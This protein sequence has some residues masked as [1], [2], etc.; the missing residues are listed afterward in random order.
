MNTKI[1]IFGILCCIMATDFTSAVAQTPN[2]EKTFYE[3]LN[4]IYNKRKKR[5]I[6]KC[7]ML[8]FL[9]NLKIHLIYELCRVTAY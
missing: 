1:V 4:Q 7:D 8:L 9:K 6:K 5:F 2:C 3:Q